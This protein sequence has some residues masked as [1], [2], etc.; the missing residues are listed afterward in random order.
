MG[1]PISQ[2]DQAPRTETKKIELKPV[3][4]A[5]AKE[6]F[7]KG[8]SWLKEL[9]EKT[10]SK[11]RE[12]LEKIKRISVPTKKYLV[13]S[14]NPEISE[15]SQKN[16][17][18]LEK[19]ESFE[20]GIPILE[21][22]D[23]VKYR[24]QV[25]ELY[26]GEGKGNGK[27]GEVFLSD[28]KAT[29]IFYQPDSILNAYELAF[30]RKY[31]G[32]AGMPK[33]IGVVPNGYQMER[34]H[35]E[36]LAKRVNKAFNGE[37][38]K[39]KKS[40]EV[41]KGILSADQVQ[42]LID[43]VAEFHRGTGRVHGDLGHWDDIIITPEGEIRITDPEWERIGDQTPQSE[44]QSLYDFFTRQG[45]SNLSLPE[46]IPDDVAI[47]NLND[48]RS[49]VLENLVIDPVS[50]R[51]NKYKDQKVNVKISEDGEVLVSC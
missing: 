39:G 17:R 47:K 18:P 25:E 33:F 27:W 28:E 26:G 11:P 31:G 42:D 29:K 8:K 7:E 5:K 30:V 43:K 41:W 34:I 21:G 44:L 19:G 4:E 46:T 35:G 23:A 15:I 9:W 48:F 1:E 40:S 6:L 36:S 2:P 50:H 10:N 14:L 38:Q 3:R 51:I 37:G 20:G 45:Y 32:I 49:K 13:D 24:Q 22:E 16:F 12:V